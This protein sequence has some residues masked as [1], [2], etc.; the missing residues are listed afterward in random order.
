MPYWAFYISQKGSLSLNGKKT[1]RRGDY[2]ITDHYALTGDLDAYYKGLSY[3][4]SSSFDD[5]ISEELAPYNLKGMKAFTPAYLSGFYADTS[6]VD[7][8]VYQG[9]A[10]YTASAETTERIASDGTFA[11]F[12]MDTIRPEQLH[13][14]TETIDSTMF[15]VWFLSYRKKDRVAYATV[16]GQTG[17]VVA[18]IPIDPKRYLLGSLLLAIPIFALLAWSAFLQPSSLV[19]TTLLLS[20]LSIGVYCYECVSI[21]Q[22]DTGA[23]DRGKMFIQSKKASAADKPKTPEVQLEPAAKTIHLAGFFRS[24]LRYF[25][26]GY[27]SCIRYRI[28]TITEPQFFPWLPSSCR[29]SVLSMRIICCPP[30]GCHNLT[31]REVMTVRKIKHILT[32]FVFCLILSASTIPVCASAVSASNEETGY[33]YVLDDSA[34]FLTDSQENS[35]Q[36][37]LYDLTAYCNVAFV[38]TTEHS[39]SSTEDFAAD[40]FD[41]IFGPHANGTIFVI[42]RCLNEIYLYSD[43]QAHKIITNS[44]ARSIT[45]NTYTYARDKDY[46]TCAYKIFAQIETLMQGKRIAEPMRYL[47]SALLAI[48]AALFLNL[49]FAL[50]SS[51]SHKADRRQ[52]MT[53]LYAQMQIH[54]PRTQ[55]IRQTRTYS[56]VSSG[57]SG[58]GHSGGG[59]GGG[60]H[61]GGGGGHSI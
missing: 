42:D 28:S 31:N 14:K 25:R 11:G 61:S 35:L 21:H 5:N 15:P 18:D 34:D 46:Y 49:F 48:V 50:W 23:N 38:T 10:E 36:K 13:T 8:K 57:S 37:Q 58:G 41:D 24:V 9:D 55:F 17:L 1:S 12:T 54:N 60:G 30:A 27:G 16:N 52:V 32:A 33:V 43:G 2:I 29:S 53:G 26:L 6:D 47:C 19:M 59:G 4:A 51:R 39:K 45:D 56:P 40:Y 20:L 22:K 3:D 7:A 44:R